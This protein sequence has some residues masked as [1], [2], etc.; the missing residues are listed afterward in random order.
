LPSWP[1]N[2][3]IQLI[4]TWSPLTKTGRTQVLTTSFAPASTLRSRSISLSRPTRGGSRF[5]CM[6]AFSV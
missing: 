4:T 2:S 1:V 5:S 6:L 3:K